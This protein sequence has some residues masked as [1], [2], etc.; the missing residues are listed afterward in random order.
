[1]GFVKYD[2][3]HSY[4]ATFDAALDEMLARIDA[5]YTPLRIVMFATTFSNEQYAVERYRLLRAFE[6]RYG[7]AAPLV[8]YVAQSPLAATYIMEIQMVSP[9]TKLSYKSLGG[10]RYITCATDR[11]EMLFTAGIVPVDLSKSIYAQSKEVFQATAAILKTEGMEVSDIVRQ[12]NFIELITS[13]GPEGQHYQLFND[14]RTEFYS[15]ANW[16]GGYPAATGIGTMNG[17]IMVEIDAGRTI[18]SS[19]IVAIDN[20]LQV[21]AHE[22]SPQV[23]LGTEQ[24]STPKFERAKAVDYGNGDVNVYISGT[25]AIRGED[26]LADVDIAAQTIYT[27]EN[28]EY[29]VGTQNMDKYGIYVKNSPEIKLFR[30]YLKLRSDFLRAKDIVSQR[31][32]NIPTM[33][34]ITD[35]CRDELL[36]EIEGVAQYD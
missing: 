4:C 17:G 25:A 27:L 16:S 21:A 24:L 12:W 10:Y 3:F 20:S 29:L 34:V 30:V 18:D 26:S 13:I 15:G 35:V 11:V 32:P 6:E 8:T 31:Y 22:Y 9:D 1:M 33:Y 23:L 36:I 2:I 14:A 7:A 5:R 28:I 19:R